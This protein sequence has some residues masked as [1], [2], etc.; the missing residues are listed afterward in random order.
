MKSKQKWIVVAIGAAVALSAVAVYLVVGAVELR[1]ICRTEGFQVV[2]FDDLAG[3]MPMEF[4]YSVLP[5]G[6]YC[7]RGDQDS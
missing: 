4:G 2:H 6:F 1:R 5:P 7:E 3:S